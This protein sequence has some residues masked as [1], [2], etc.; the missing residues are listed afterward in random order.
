MTFQDGL[1]DLV[2]KPVVYSKYIHGSI[3]HLLFAA[4]GGEAASMFGEHPCISQKMPGFEL[5]WRTLPLQVLL[6]WNVALR[7][8]RPAP[9]RRS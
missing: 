4:N 6:P 2:D 1:Q 3:F 9:S 7:R 8:K 5:E